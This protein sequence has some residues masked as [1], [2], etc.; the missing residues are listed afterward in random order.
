MSSWKSLVG[1]HYHANA[2]LFSIKKVTRLISLKL[3]K[4]KKPQ[5]VHV[6]LQH[7]LHGH[8]R[9]W[10]TRS[11]IEGALHCI[12]Q[13]TTSIPSC[14]FCENNMNLSSGRCQH[15]GYPRLYVWFNFFNHGNCVNLD[16]VQTIQF[17][18]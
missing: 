2:T 13:S 15:S 3:L 8:G 16:D 12:D 4:N 7:T 9:Y 10:S 6:F 11:S 5:F 1:G 17:N 18:P 14:P